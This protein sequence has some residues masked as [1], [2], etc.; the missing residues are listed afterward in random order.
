M[1]E[2]IKN[3]IDTYYRKKLYI[4]SPEFSLLHLKE[5]GFSP[6]HIFD[7]GAYNG[8]F[9][10]LVSKVWPNASI[11]CF[12]AL[13]SKINILHSLNDKRVKIVPGLIGERD[14]EKILFHEKE[15]ASSILEEQ[16]ENS[17]PVNYHPMRKLDT[18]IKEF[19][20]PIPNLLKIDTQGYE[21]YV[22][23]GFEENLSKCEVIL[24]E[25]N[26]VDIHK[27]VKLADE[28]ISFLKTFGFVIF[29]ICQLHRKPSDKVLWQADF[30]F[31]KENSFLRS[32][33]A[34]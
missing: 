7:V 25:L 21:Y 30:I 10:R 5:L 29:D 28:V 4:P 32:N 24:A 15:S 19:S 14:E 8:D 11:T 23:K 31:V 20:L 1:K 2:L 33:K 16:T 12:E 18:C 22:L 6:E 13:E 9:V 3:Y 26:F 17:F 27:N 34:W